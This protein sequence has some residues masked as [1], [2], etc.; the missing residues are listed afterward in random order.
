MRQ[1]SQFRPRTCG[2]GSRC[3]ATG[4]SGTDVV[5]ALVIGL[6]YGPV[7][8]ASSAILADRAPRD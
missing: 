8:P 3:L 2:A 5:G 7:T 1:V 6:G 4:S